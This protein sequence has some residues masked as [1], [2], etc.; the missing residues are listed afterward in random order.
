MSE[1]NETNGS[2]IVQDGELNAF[3]EIDVI[4]AAERSIDRWAKVQQIALKLTTENDWVNQNENP[5]L[6]HSGAE[7]IAR[8]FRV[9]ITNVKKEKIFSEDEKGERYYIWTYDGIASMPGI[10]QQNAVG[11]CSSRDS[12]YGMKGG[13]YKPLSTIDEP[14]VMKAAH[15]N[16]IVNAITHMLGLRNLTWKQLENAGVDISKI[17]KVEY[18]TGS[19][20]GS[21]E[22]NLSEK[23]LKK[24]DE[25]GKML[26]DMYAGDQEAIESYCIR[27]STFTIKEGEDKGKEIKGKL[28]KYWTEKQ[29]NWHH[30]VI[31]KEYDEVM[32]EK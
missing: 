27:V 30:S 25:I 20:G 18:K 32:K 23:A 29:I 10:G 16:L 14:S 28:Y 7:R 12:L 22:K 13:E 15:T 9:S 21:Q 19:K 2:I 1:N 4:A 24:R 31:K 11:A 6:I 17:K 5:Y 3:G 26:D 8:Q